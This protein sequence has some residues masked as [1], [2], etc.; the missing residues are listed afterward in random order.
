[1]EYNII[2]R[3]IRIIIIAATERRQKDNDCDNDANVCVGGG[4]RGA[5]PPPEGLSS[6]HVAAA[7]PVLIDLLRERARARASSRIF[8][9][10]NILCTT[11]VQYAR[12][13]RPST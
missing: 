2:T 6:N 1:M 8:V 12:R 9:T 10:G 3:R 11:T 7:V 4:D 13:P 5:V